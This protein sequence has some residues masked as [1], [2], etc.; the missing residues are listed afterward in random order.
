M[1]FALS[2]CSA[3]SVESTATPE[4]TVEVTPEPT[5]ALPDPTVRPMRDYN[6]VIIRTISED[7]SYTDPRD[8]LV[9][10]LSLHC[11]SPYVVIENNMAASDAVN[12]AIKAIDETF[13]TGE[14]Y[15]Y[16]DEFG[17]DI[18]YYRALAEDNFTLYESGINTDSLP[19][20]I[21]RDYNI[22]RADEKLITIEFKNSIDEAEHSELSYTFSFNASDGS[23]VSDA[24]I[25]NPDFEYEREQI[26][27]FGGFRI[28]SLSD[29]ELGSGDTAIIDLVSIDDAGEDYVISDVDANCYDFTIDKVL[30]NDDGT[31]TVLDKFFYCSELYYS[32][33][34]V[35]IADNLDDNTYIRI[36]STSSSGIEVSNLI[37]FGDNGAIE[38][39]SANNPNAVG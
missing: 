23:L 26:E 35:K 33:V 18:N 3:S 6:P 37:S 5:P 30:M 36:T 27:G 29:F 8:G 10:I 20:I 2:A 1:L 24:D 22:I 4:P 19:I 15:G 21:S 39:K 11:A 32:A 7:E 14:D 13:Y 38:L 31:Y 17:V 25:N 12:E 16:G 28:E 34:Q 9:E